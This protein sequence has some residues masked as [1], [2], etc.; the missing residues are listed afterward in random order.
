M[1]SQIASEEKYFHLPTSCST[2]QRL[3]TIEE[4][5]FLNR[6]TSIFLPFLNFQLYRAES[7]GRAVLVGRA[8]IAAG[9]RK[10]P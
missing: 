7:T 9:D 2:F 1:A 5:N 6:L 4:T 10:N 8:T 3:G